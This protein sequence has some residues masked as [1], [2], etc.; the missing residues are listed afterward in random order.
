MI[1]ARCH[2]VNN[3]GPPVRRICIACKKPFEPGLIRAPWKFEPSTVHDPHRNRGGLG[4]QFP[5]SRF[6]PIDLLKPYVEQVIESA[7][8]AGLVKRGSSHGS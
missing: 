4:P 7:I 8:K 3:N 6:H 2:Y 5:V 1:C